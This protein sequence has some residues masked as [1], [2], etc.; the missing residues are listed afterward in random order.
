MIERC[1]AGALLALSLLGAAPAAAADWTTF[2]HDLAR[3]NENPAE[4]NLGPANAPS[5]REVWAAPLAGV[6]NA[7]PLVVSGVRVA[8][9]RRAQIVLAAT[10]DGVL[11]AHDSVTGT[12]LWR[13][14]LGVQ[15]TRCGALPG[16]RYGISATPSTS[17]V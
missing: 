9:G 1:A 17:R 14:A 16:G 3:T 10:E 6:A 13:R 11:S 7:Q 8:G 12:R 15:P 2:G 5:L 4:S